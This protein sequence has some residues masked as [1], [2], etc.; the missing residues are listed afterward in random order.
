MS[1][2]VS[3]RMKILVV[4]DQE[5]IREVV[6]ISLE[7]VG[8]WQVVFAEP[9]AGVVARAEE[10]QPDAIVLD[11]KM[12]GLDGPSTL[13]KL[14]ANQRTNS[15]PAILLTASVQKEER[16]QYARLG[17]AAIL[18]KPF[19]PMCLPSQIAEVLGWRI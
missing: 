17:F 19:D 15:I 1:D 5:E 16:E 2:A 10:E 14:R 13:Q 12:P 8:G 7:Q 6:G 3:S 9:G 11:A 4:E 18:N